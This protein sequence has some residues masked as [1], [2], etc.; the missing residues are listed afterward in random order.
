M[1]SLCLFEG[2]YYRLTERGETLAP[3]LRPTG[4]QVWKNNTN[5]TSGTFLCWRFAHVHLNLLAVELFLCRLGSSVVYQTEQVACSLSELQPSLKW[6]G[7]K[8]WT[9]NFD[10]ALTLSSCGPAGP[11]SKTRVA[12]WPSLALILVKRHAYSE[13]LPY[14][15]Q[16]KRWDH[17]WVGWFLKKEEKKELSNSESH[18]ELKVILLIWA[19]KME[20]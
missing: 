1:L 10:S 18:V 11:L 12:R 20:T 15:L 4:V 7:F 13:S 19:E 9:F 6:N 2:K 8:L 17:V 14:S 5:Q 16:N 3:L